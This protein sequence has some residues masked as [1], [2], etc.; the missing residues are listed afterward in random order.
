MEAALT[1]DHENNY[2]S[3]DH[4]QT[5]YYQTKEVLV[6]LLGYITF[7]S[8]ITA[9]LVVANTLFGQENYDLVLFL[10]ILII[11]DLITGMIAAVSQG[12]QI[13]SRKAF[14]TA[15]KT[16]VYLLFFSS[17]Y[18]THKIVPYSDF[19]STGVLSFL[20]ITEL[21]SVME[22]MSKMGYSLPQK[23]LN[24]IKDREVGGKTDVRAT[25]FGNGKDKK[26]K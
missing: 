21:L 10:G 19:I 5:V 15:T 8:V 1:Q 17:A 13:E 3:M 7:K 24:Q 9:L 18:L 12:Q 26:G 6:S 20:A 4:I 22:N 14:K 23:L 25:S 11:F 2:S 16:F